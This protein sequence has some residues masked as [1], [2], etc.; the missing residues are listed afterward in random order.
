M[1]SPPPC[2]EG[3]GEGGK[4]DVNSVAVLLSKYR[5]SIL[6]IIGELQ[7]F[8]FEILSDDLSGELA[9]LYVVVSGQRVSSS[10]VWIPTF[11]PELQGY[12]KPHTQ[13]WSSIDFSGL[14][15]EEAFALFHEVMETEGVIRGVGPDDIWRYHLVHSLDDAVDGWEIYLFDVAGDKHIVCRENLVTDDANGSDARFVSCTLPRAE[16]IRIC[17]EFVSLFP[18]QSKTTMN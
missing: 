18:D 8:G 3:R 5:K 2:G 9:E 10:P 17:K 16:F 7:R 15:D 14:S 6:R 4:G 13:V 12:I 11:V 1:I